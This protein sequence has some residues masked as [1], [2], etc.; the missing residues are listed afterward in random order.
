MPAMPSTSPTNDRGNDVMTGHPRS[1]FLEKCGGIVGCGPG[2]VSD[3]G[4][5]PQPDAATPRVAPSA[6]EVTSELSPAEPSA[7]VDG[8]L[9]TLTVTARNPA[10]HAV[11]VVLPDRKGGSWGTSYPFD[12]GGSQSRILGGDLAVDIGVT[13]FAAHETKR[14]VMDFAVAPYKLDPLDHLPGQGGNGVA[15][16]T[17]TYTFRGAY[18]DHWAANIVAVLNQ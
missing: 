4:L 15:L 1:V 8:G 5:P 13:Y 3:A 14:D 9:F 7:R 12:I 6:L 17:G 18:G 11:I 16:S 10:D 2:C